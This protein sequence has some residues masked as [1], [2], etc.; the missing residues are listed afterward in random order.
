MSNKLEENVEIL[1][2][3]YLERFKTLINTNRKEDAMSIGQEY[4]C[5][6]EVEDDDYQWFYVNYQFKLQEEN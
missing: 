6:R 3:H 4:I 5:N 2:N 1:S